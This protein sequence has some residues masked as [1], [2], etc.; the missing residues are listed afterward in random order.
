[1]NLAFHNRRQSANGIERADI[2]RRR[3]TFIFV[4]GFPFNL[5]SDWLSDLLLRLPFLGASV[6]LFQI[7]KERS[8]L[9]V[10][11]STL[12]LSA[13]ILDRV[14]AGRTAD[15]QE[16]RLE[17]GRQLLS[18]LRSD[19]T[20]LF[21]ASLL[22]A[23]VAETGS[24]LRERTELLTSELKAFSV[25]YSR[26][27]YLQ[28]KV[29]ADFSPG[30]V[31]SFDRCPIV[32]TSSL[33]ALVPFTQSPLLQEMGVPV[34]CNAIDGTPVVHDRFS[35]PNYNSVVI[36]KSG[37]GKSFFMKLLMLRESG[38][39]SNRIF[40]IDPLGEFFAVGLQ[41]GA[42]VVNVFHE[43]LGLGSLKMSE[44]ITFGHYLTRFVQSI[45][46]LT[47]REG[48]VFKQLLT[49]YATDNSEQYLS[50]FFEA[51]PH[52]HDAEL[53]F[54]G[55]MADISRISFLLEGKC[56][57]SGNGGHIVFDMGSVSK[58]MLE[59]VICLVSGLVFELCRRAHGRKTLVLDEAWTVSRSPASSA[60]VSEL[61]RHSRHYGLSVLLASQN[62][63]DFLCQDPDG[64]LLNN[65]S[66][67]F[68]FRHE[69]LSMRMRSFF[70]LN[71]GDLEFIASSHPRTEGVGKCILV[72]SGM[73][74]PL[75]V[76]CSDE[77]REVCNSEPTLPVTPSALMSIM[78]ISKLDEAVS[79][80]GEAMHA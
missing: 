71:D 27:K 10:E 1:M 78:A 21:Y 12:N 54:G 77:E 64:G 20:R 11:R 41:S 52:L 53:S 59:D 19:R 63:D 51:L 49:K 42:E 13:E 3:I 34:G 23:V 45:F 38:F 43:G 60:F 5:P 18:E 70:E 79:L 4:T 56:V 22:F 75:I 39:A 32:S 37:S 30:T 74:V 62:F 73:K 65:C 66:H 6:S 58:G 76:H 7:S 25:R 8:I 26:L 68:V 57:L 35:T 31:P 15:Y 29:L 69:K 9:M 14:N 28:F 33:P 50:S 80:I 24:E 47:E 2:G 46:K 40:V 72:T 61:M 17:L 55:N 48:V 16:T 44:A 67:F 36:G